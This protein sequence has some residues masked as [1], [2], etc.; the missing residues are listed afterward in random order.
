MAFWLGS[1]DQEPQKLP[2]HHAWK[3][4]TGDT[5]KR[6]SASLRVAYYLISTAGLV[7][8]KSQHKSK[9][10]PPVLESVSELMLWSSK[11]RMLKVLNKEQLWR[12]GMLAEVL[13]LFVRF[14]IFWVLLT[15]KL[16]IFHVCW[17]KIIHPFLLGKKPKSNQN[18]TQTYRKYQQFH[19]VFLL[20]AYW[21]QNINWTEIKQLRF[22]LVISFN[23]YILSIY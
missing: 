18:K 6:Y 13:E 5:I 9:S 22:L 19:L 15:D 10:Q 3:S 23:N 17:W 11:E 1:E 21:N 2:C 7:M 8:C 12:S 16:N 14:P 4:I 20:T